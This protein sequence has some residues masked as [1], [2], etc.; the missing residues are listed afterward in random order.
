MQ[1]TIIGGGIGGLTLALTLRRQGIAARV[2]EQAPEIRPVGAGIT[3]GANALRVCQKLEI[4]D[5]ITAAGTPLRRFSIGSHSGALIS[6]FD[7]SAVVPDLATP[8]VGIHR[9]NLHRILL[10]GLD[11]DQLAPGHRLTEIHQGADDVVAVFANG[12][13][14]PGT[15]LIGADGLGSTVRTRILGE[16]ST[17][18]A[19]Q[20]CFRG[21]CPVGDIS[22]VM[23]ESREIWGPGGSRIGI[24]PIATDTLYWFATFPTD[25]LLNLADN[26]LPV[27]EQ[28]FADWHSPIPQVIAATTAATILRNDLYDRLPIRGWSQDRVALLGDAV[29]PTTPNLGQGAAMA[30][31]SAAVLGNCLAQCGDIHEAFATYENLR[32]R[33]TRRITKQSWRIGQI[34]T[35]RNPVLARVRNLGARVLAPFNNQ[36]MC[37]VLNHRIPIG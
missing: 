20:I 22:W 32:Q 17:R 27:L 24:V 19:R 5:H 15:I 23:D 1:V 14:E 30:I 36:Q 12:H 6:T 34:A 26:P 8:A 16:S 29:H 13:A 2:F 21:V 10:A 31:E 11:S 9:A 3:L 35:I 18:D 37:W 28:W 25:L 4:I 33:R 7:M